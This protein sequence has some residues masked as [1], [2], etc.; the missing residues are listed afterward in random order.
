IHYRR[1]IAE[2]PCTVDI[3][4]VWDVSRDVRI[5][6]VRTRE[7]DFVL[8][9]EQHLLDVDDAVAEFV[10]HGNASRLEL[11]EQRLVHREFHVRARLDNQSDRHACVVSRDD[12][13]RESRQLDHVKSHVDADV[14]VAHEID[15]TRVAVFKRRVAQP[16]LSR[17]RF[18]DKKAKSQ[19]EPEGKPRTFSC[20]HDGN[21]TSNTEILPCY[22]QASVDC[23]ELAWKKLFEIVS[24]SCRQRLF[25]KTGFFGDSPGLL[26]VTVFVND[27]DA[28]G[29]DQ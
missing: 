22:R 10:T 15:Q 12:L 25:R 2:V 27:D 8:T 24:K 29:V 18:R 9:R 28:I 26:E 7:D 13:V 3:I 19:N 4:L 14:L 23:I 1:V 21:S 6:E 5:T 11:V 16:F 20:D 17:S